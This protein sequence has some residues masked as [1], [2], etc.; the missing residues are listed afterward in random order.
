[1]RSGFEVPGGGKVCKYWPTDLW[2]SK[3]PIGQI[4]RRTL[5]NTSAIVLSHSAILPFLALSYPDYLIRPRPFQGLARRSIHTSVG[6]GNVKLN[7]ISM[8]PFFFRSLLGFVVVR[9]L[10]F[11][12]LVRSGVGY[13][14]L[15]T[16]IQVPVEGMQPIEPAQ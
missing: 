6:H 14:L 12:V 10:F 16:N 7:R 11:I 13:R 2:D 9:G 5:P 3:P 4:T 15:I 8:L 1:M